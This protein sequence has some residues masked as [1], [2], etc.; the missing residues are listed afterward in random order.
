MKITEVK[1]LDD[2]FDG[3]YIKELFFDCPF[4]REVII[5][6]KAKG[7]LKYFPSFA[8][9][10]FSFDVEDLMN[11][12]GVEGNYSARIWIKNEN[13]VDLFQNMLE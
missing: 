9:P 5:S 8:R 11:V 2:C 13:A 1:K 4:T 3:S 12:K 10:F 6:L 7:E